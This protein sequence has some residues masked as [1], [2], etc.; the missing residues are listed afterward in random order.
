MVAPP[1]SPSLACW[2][3]TQ[4]KGSLIHQRAWTEP[5][6]TE[7]AGDLWTA[8]IGGESAVCRRCI[9]ELKQKACDIP[10]KR[11]NAK[12][13]FFCWQCV[14]K[15]AAHQSILVNT[16]EGRIFVKSTFNVPG[17][18]ERWQKSGRCTS[19]LPSFHDPAWKSFHACITSGIN[20]I[21]NDIAAH[22]H[23]AVH[24]TEHLGKN[25]RN[26]H[27]HERLQFLRRNF[28]HEIA[29]LCHWRGPCACG[30]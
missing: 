5:G 30:R 2:R 21:K 7:P 11:K 1:T 8:R 28:W 15:S 25:R 16:R 23:K 26:Y 22:L 6:S 29:A 20:I 10:D 27:P 13:S 9:S 3:C 14:L 4:I 12:Q 19:T 17:F 18:F 24:S